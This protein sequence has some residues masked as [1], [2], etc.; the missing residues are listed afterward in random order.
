AVAAF[1]ALALAQ[2]CLAFTSGAR[3][4]GPAAPGAG[5]AL[6]VPTT[7]G[8]AA[9]AA[10]AGP[11]AAARRWSAAWARGGARAARCCC[12]RARCAPAAGRAR[13]AGRGRWCARTVSAPLAT[14]ECAGPVRLAAADALG[15][16]GLLRLLRWQ[17]LLRPGRLRGLRLLRGAR[18]RAGPR[19]LRH[20]AVRLR[21]GLPEAEVQ[22]RALRAA[23]GRPRDARQ[24]RR[25]RG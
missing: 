16:A 9:S 13:R 17:G 14:V 15:A 20:R 21:R 22:R 2:T 24:R 1:C 25:R 10:A 4:A 18:R 7:G 12:W 19:M 23:P 5:A 3:L 8:R 11:K 6:G